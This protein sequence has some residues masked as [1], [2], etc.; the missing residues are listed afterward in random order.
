[1]YQTW[2]AKLLGK[3]IAILTSPSPLPFT[4][5]A[6]ICKCTSIVC[7]IQNWQCWSCLTMRLELCVEFRISIAASSYLIV[8]LDTYWASLPSSFQKRLSTAGWEKT[9]GRASHW[10]QSHGVVHTARIEG[11]VVRHTIQDEFICFLQLS[12]IL[13]VNQLNNIGECK[14]FKSLKT[15]FR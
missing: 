9:L 13:Q 1:M 15:K 12:L 3:N 14:L 8:I 6:P 5:T 7:K 2:S 4:R 11:D 10:H